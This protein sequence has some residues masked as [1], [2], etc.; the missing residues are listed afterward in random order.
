MGNKSGRA[1]DGADGDSHERRYD[2]SNV[3]V[4]IMSMDRESTSTQDRT[5]IHMEPTKLAKHLLFH[6][7]SG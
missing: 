1:I 4:Y 7:S 3:V 5:R 6:I 2:L